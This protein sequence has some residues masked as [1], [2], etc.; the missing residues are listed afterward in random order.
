MGLPSIAPAQGTLQ[1]GDSYLVRLIN[2]DLVA[3]EFLGET[4]LDDTIPAWRFRTL[5][6][7]A[8]I[9]RREV[10]EITP[11]EK[12][13][14]HWHRIFIQPTAE[15]IGEHT[16]VG[17]AGLFALYGGIGFQDWLS[18]AGAYTLVPVMSAGEQL[19]G[20]NTKFTLLTSPNI[21]T[22][23]R[24]SLAFGAQVSALS[25]VNQILHLYGV[26]S[27]VG[28]RSHLSAMVFAKVAGDDLLT[29]RAGSM[30]S[31]T[32]GYATGAVGIG[33][34]LDVQLPSRTGP[35]SAGRVVEQRHPKPFADGDSL[36]VS[37]WQTQR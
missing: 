7:T 31:V 34:G 15:P 6:G 19:W 30:G 29:V 14:R 17:L 2:G 33:V 27:F 20:L 18:L 16:F 10:A 13:Y 5:V 36:L 32:F 37:A 3:G 28:S 4:L 24:V 8:T 21:L 9:A 11:Q 26:A 22:P 35:P 12:A 23:G 25:A 1:R